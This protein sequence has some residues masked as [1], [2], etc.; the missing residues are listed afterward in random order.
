MPI[1]QSRY[2]VR[3]RIMVRDSLGRATLEANPQRVCILFCEATM[4]SYTISTLPDTPETGGIMILG[5]RYPF[6]V[7]WSKHG[8][9]CTIPW[10]LCGLQPGTDALIIEVLEQ[11]TG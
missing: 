2:V 10:F 8:S 9:L 7:H 1:D 6:E 3:Q 4:G 5:D 11:P